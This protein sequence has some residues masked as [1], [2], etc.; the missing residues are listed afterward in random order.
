MTVA[1]DIATAPSGPVW[2]NLTMTGHRQRDTVY[3]T[4]PVLA[5]LSTKQ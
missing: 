4:S 1:D 3:S 2:L 5:T